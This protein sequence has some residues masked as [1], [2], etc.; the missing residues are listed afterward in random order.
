MRTPVRER[1][2]RR[3]LLVVDDEPQILEIISE[4]FS[5]KYDV[6]AAPSA[7]AAVQLFEKQRPDVVLLD[8]NMPG[9]DGLKLLTFLRKAEPK[10]PV[11]IVTAHTE[12]S[13]AAKALEAGA[14]GYVPKPFTL[15][16]MEHLAAAAVDAS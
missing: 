14:F 9:V 7:T 13:I 4:H 10:V 1:A 15:V 16:Y 3:R 11:I 5:Q 12:V 2:G 8:I 6:D